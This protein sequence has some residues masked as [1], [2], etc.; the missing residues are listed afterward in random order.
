MWYFQ[1]QTGKLR[2]GHVFFPIRVLVN[3]FRP[4]QDGKS[5]RFI[6]DISIPKPVLDKAATEQG[7][8]VWKVLTL[9]LLVKATKKKGCIPSKNVL[10]NTYDVGA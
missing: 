2:E 5:C 10:L 1:Q 4:G 7:L 8:T 9:G 6:G 3:Q